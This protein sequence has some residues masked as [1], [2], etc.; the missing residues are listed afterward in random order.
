[1]VIASFGRTIGIVQEDGA[2]VAKVKAQQRQRPK[3]PADPPDAG[4]T[5]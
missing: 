3:P 2:V 5:P 4:S 1:L